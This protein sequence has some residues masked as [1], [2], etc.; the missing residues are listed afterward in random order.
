[1]GHPS[2]I[3]I[4][5][6]KI[7]FCIIEMCHYLKIKSRGIPLD[8]R[9]IV[10]SV[11]FK[12]IFLNTFKWLVKLITTGGTPLINTD[13]K[14]KNSILHHRNVSLSQNKI[15]SIDLNF[16]IDRSVWLYNLLQYI[17]TK[18]VCHYFY[19]YGLI[20]LMLCQTYLQI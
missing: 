20:F 3:E 11:F 16:I 7:I 8:L 17:L 19:L 14:G 15:K 13:N 4:I 9:L 2:L 6:V 1:M 5:K 18:H 10:A 12:I